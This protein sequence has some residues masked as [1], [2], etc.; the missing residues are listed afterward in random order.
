MKKVYVHIGTHKTGSSY[1][2]ENLKLYPWYVSIGYDLGVA[3]YQNSPL[4]AHEIKKWQE[5]MKDNLKH[6]VNFISCEGFCGDPYRNY[7]NIDVIAMNLSEI[8]KDYQVKII[9][10][11]RRQDQFIESLYNQILKEGE[12]INFSDFLKTIDIYGFDWKKILN[13]YNE[14]FDLAWLH[15]DILMK[16]R[17]D[18]IAAIGQVMDKRFL[19][20]NKKNVN[21]S[22]NE[23]GIHLSKLCNPVLDTDGRAKF[24]RFLEQN[25]CKKPQEESGFFTREERKKLMEYYGRNV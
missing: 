19:E 1:I 5:I 20:G 22:Y 17:C 18:I 12:N 6:E 10:F 3:L 24:R 15:Y 9:V 4:Q 21:C 13:K 25:F 14:Y 8:L 2:Q 11:T 16:T 7:A 23:T